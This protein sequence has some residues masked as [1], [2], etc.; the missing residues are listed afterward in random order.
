MVM[1][2]HGV[3]LSGLHRPAGAAERA[4]ERC[5]VADVP[6]VDATA[7][8]S[9]S[10]Y[11]RFRGRSLAIVPGRVPAET[12]YRRPIRHGRW[13][14]RLVQMR[15]FSG[16]VDDLAADDGEVRCDIRDLGLGAGEIV[17]VGNDEIGQLANL[18]ATFLAFLIGEPGDVL[19]PHPE[20]GLAIQAVALGVEW[21]GGCGRA[22]GDRPPPN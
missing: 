15:E 19:G 5:E 10:W 16:P 21:R 4:P 6:R 17:A 9:D 11:C 13:R 1:S 14:R 18:D 12:A 8:R 2:F 3:G 22:G 20:R 7:G